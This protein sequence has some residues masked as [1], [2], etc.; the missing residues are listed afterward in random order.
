MPLKS[1]FQ[2]TMGQTSS[3]SST[4]DFT[5]SPPPADLIVVGGGVSGA[6][7]LLHLIERVKHG[8]SLKK[9]TFV[10]KND[11][12]QPGITSFPDHMESIASTYADTIGLQPSNLSHYVRWRKDVEKSS[13]LS[14]QGYSEYVQAMW[15]KA[16][17]DARRVGLDV[18]IIHKV[19][20]DLDRQS[21]GTFFLSLN[22]DTKLTAQYVVLALGNFTAVVNT[23]LLNLPGFIPRPWPKSQLEYIIKD[24]SVLIVGSGLSAVDTAIRLS[25]SGHQGPI[26]LMSRS[27]CLPKV[28]GKPIPFSRRYALHVLARRVEENPDESL[29]Q[30]TSGLME[31]ISHVTNGDWSWLQ[32]QGPPIKQL[33][34]DIRKAQT[35]E[36]GWQGVLQATAPVIERYWRCLSTKSQELFMEQF[37]GPW[38]RYCHGMPVTTAEK[39][40]ELMEKSQLRVVQGDW[41]QWDGIFKAQT[42]VGLLE[43]SHVIEATGQECRIDH[44]E[45]PLIHS[46]VKKGFLAPHPAGG[47][48][49]DFNSLR[50]TP[51]LHVMGSLTRGTHFHTIDIDRAVAHAA[52]VAD[53]VTQEPLARSLHIAIFLGSDLFSHLMASQLVPQ[54]LAAGHMPFIFLPEHKGGRKVPPFE[55]RELGFLERELLQKHVIPYFKDQHPEGASHMTVAQMT[56]A[57][58]I[59]VQ[60]VPNVNSASFINCLREYHID[61]GL[62]LRCYQRF[63]S[64]I[65]RYLSGPRRLLN[66]HPGILPAYRGVM[67]T[68]R[69]MGDRE[70]HF[71]YTL[72]NVDEDFDSGDVVDIRKHPIDYS[73]SMLHFMNDVYGI[74]VEMVA[75]AID[76]IARGKDLPR[77]PQNAEDSRY[78]SFPTKEDFEQYR[79]DGVRLVDAESIVKVI[80]ESFAPPTQQDAF[81]VYIQDVVQS[82]YQENQDQ[83]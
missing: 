40:L 52:R 50:A 9:V 12:A 24:S 62:S 69:A 28:Q 45:S 30:I 14:C 76:H 80:V 20:N 18:S 23:H 16:L 27:G 15:T 67:T 58:G 72:H 35:G 47:V 82:W 48:K 25:Q 44:I 39:A 38:N 60:E 37:F 1:L 73:K 19:I 68:I 61:M 79:R 56:S 26:T 53:A 65:I 64:D 34:H 8:K 2:F 6:A 49:V 70:T 57:Y 81:R 41:V 59:L 54:L 29:L 4:S 74:G 13:M 55:L 31:E 21:D 51:G 33:Q 3:Q 46:A 17:D 78:Y 10:Q 22:N 11:I 5:D 71:G 7:I 36:T 77:L 66:L 83:M 75:D 42:S 32:S 63:K 43:V